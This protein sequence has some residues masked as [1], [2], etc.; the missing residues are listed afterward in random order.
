ME[1]TL[2]KLISNHVWVLSIKAWRYVNLKVNLIKWMLHYKSFTWC[3][4]WVY[5]D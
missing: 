4:L 1:L 3:Y 5:G 2:V